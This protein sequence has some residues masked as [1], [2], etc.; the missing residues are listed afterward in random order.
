MSGTSPG[1]PRKLQRSDIRDGFESGSRELDE[2]ITRYALQDQRANSATT[3][4]SCS[5]GLVVGYYSIAVGAVAKAMAPTAIARTA[6]AEVSCI[7][8]SRLAVDRN[9][10]R[11][12]IGA[13]LLRDALERT[14]LLSN[15]VAARAVIIH[16]RDIE[17]R[18][19]F[20]SQLD[21]QPSPMDD[22][23]LMISMKDVQTIFGS[24]PEVSSG[25][26][27]DSTSASQSAD[28]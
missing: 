7:L 20:T 6:S 4:V 23:Q 11:Q 10:Q 24:Q 27:Q 2:W 14:A 13:G 16:A 17:A 12:G 18:S 21:F 28:S 3:Y 26:R 1:F 5:R 9:W 22:L 25:A 19:F 15:A 8:I